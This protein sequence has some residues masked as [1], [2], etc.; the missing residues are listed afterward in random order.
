M[1]TTIP[2]TRVVPTGA[3]APSL[4]ERLV[5][6][7]GR[8]SGFDY[9]R[10][11]LA[12]SVIGMHAALTTGG[13]H[14]NILLWT[15]PLRPFVRAI[16]PMFFA[17]SGF[18]IAGSLERCRTLVSF[19]GLRVIRIY[20]AL[21]VE[22]MLSAFLIGPMVTTNATLQSYFLDHRFF[23]YMLNALGDIHYYLPGVFTQNPF[24]DYVNKQLWTVPYELGCYVCISLLALIGLVKRPFLAPL[25]VALICIG[26]IGFHSLKGHNH[27]YL[28]QAVPGSL[29]IVGFLCGISLYL[30]REKISWDWRLCV[31]VTLVGLVCISTTAILDSVGV[32]LLA[33]TTVWIGLTNLKR[34]FVIRSADLSYGVFLYGFVIQQ[35]FAFLFPGLRVWWA[36]ILVCVPSALI[37]A[38]LSWNLVEKPALKLRKP[39]MKLENMLFPKAGDGFSQPG[40]P[41]GDQA[42]SRWFG[43]ALIQRWRRS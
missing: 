11:V 42:A 12:V 29:L 7:E 23:T 9:M 8:P 41:P 17:L 24:P 37:F 2:D 43:E 28:V 16:L 31:P 1:E 30:Y 26:R 36:S 35:L 3:G 34:I 4:A 5:A 10:I 20:P 38:A 15:S 40:V 33:Y 21:C 39:L 13:D 14:P 32:V 18:L 22:V 25:A 6:T 27:P 19:L